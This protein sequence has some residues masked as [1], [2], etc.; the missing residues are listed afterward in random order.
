MLCSLASMPTLPIK[1][2]IIASI[3]TPPCVSGAMPSQYPF[4]S[5]CFSEALGNQGNSDLL[6]DARN[7]FRYAPVIWRRWLPHTRIRECVCVC[8]CGLPLP[9]TCQRS[10]VGR[11]LL[12]WHLGSS[13]WCTVSPNP[14][15]CQA[16]VLRC[17]TVAVVRFRGKRWVLQCLEVS[18]IHAACHT[19]LWPHS[20]SVRFKISSFSMLDFSTS[21]SAEPCGLRWCASPCARVG[22]RD[23]FCPV[24]F[25]AECL[26]TRSKK[27]PAI[28]LCATRKPVIVYGN[29]M[30][31]GM[32]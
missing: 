30:V 14:A 2:F 7:R 8:V 23:T 5:I 22:V 29:V 1:R 31:I 10:C 9:E 17:I 11:A 13:L 6:D 3:R 24:V 18:P 32:S 16:T 12:N 25:R 27:H 20:L 19:Y 21:T 15:A 26:R 28:R 4:G